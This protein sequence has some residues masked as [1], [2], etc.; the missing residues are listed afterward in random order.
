MGSKR[1]GHDWATELNWTELNWG[2]PRSLVV[3][4]GHSHCR[5]TDLTSCW[6]T[7]VLHTTQCSQKQNMR[8]CLYISSC[9]WIGKAFQ[10][11]HH[12]HKWQKTKYTE[13]HQERKKKPLFKWYLYSN[14]YSKEIAKQLGKWLKYLTNL[15]SEK[16]LIS[17]LHKNS[18]NSII[19]DKYCKK[20][21]KELSKYFYRKMWYRWIETWK[22]VQLNFSSLCESVY[23]VVTDSA[24][25]WK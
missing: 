14:F 1:V 16:E 6:R 4:L 23:S 20:S 22:Y 13:L 17:R 25:S 15:I 8:V 5:C 10:M 18:Y 9:T 7:K 2:F 21:A 3:K 19:K 12:N 11:C 24:M